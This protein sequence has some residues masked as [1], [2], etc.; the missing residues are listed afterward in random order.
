MT[1]AS[2]LLTVWCLLSPLSASPTHLR[3]PDNLA[4]RLIT[5]RE[6]Q[7]FTNCPELPGYEKTHALPLFSQPLAP[8]SQIKAAPNG[9]L[10]LETPASTWEIAPFPYIAPP[11][12][13]SGWQPAVAGKIIAGQAP[14]APR[15]EAETVPSQQTP[16]VFSE[17]SPG[18]SPSAALR[19]RPRTAGEQLLLPSDRLPE[20]FSLRRYSTDEHGFFQIALYSGY[21]SINAEVAYKT[22]R[23]ASPNRQAISGLG[24]E[25][26]LSLLE[27]PPDPNSKAERS[28]DNKLPPESFGTGE[29]EISFAEIEPEGSQRFDLTDE[30]Y[31]KAKQAPFFNDVP[32]EA[33][34]LT[35]V[36]PNSLP[37]ALR[38]TGADAPALSAIRQSDTRDFPMAA[39]GSLP[40]SAV[41]DS[42]PL[43]AAAPKPM[44]ISDEGSPDDSA[45]GQADPMFS[46]PNE[47]SLSAPAP[48]FANS[49]SE[50]E[51]INDPFAERPNLSQTELGQTETPHILV[52]I[53]HFPEKDAVVEL[54]MDTRMGTLQNLIAM[55]YLVQGRFLQRW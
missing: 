49:D 1:A 20:P 5:E 11:A 24:S 17:V 32:I 9:R 18:E 55:A 48:A 53:M 51:Q 40:N 47:M 13:D 6:I 14:P 30:A 25:A 37:E 23:T 22:L 19:P 38:Q 21:S 39:T 43:P 45:Q 2:V 7:Q 4:W 50:D 44:A 15:P 31:I 12:H 36:L 34:S 10:P 27:L 8:L 29:Q 46:S 52:L 33:A 41:S 26:F 16:E 28:R 3:Y 35:A 54:A 42:L